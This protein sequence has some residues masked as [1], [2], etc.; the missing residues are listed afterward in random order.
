LLP[1][2]AQTLDVGNEHNPVQGSWEI[3]PKSGNHGREIFAR[4]DLAFAFVTDAKLSTE[5]HQSDMFC[6][7]SHVTIVP[8]QV[9]IVLIREDPCWI[10]GNHCLQL[11]PSLGAVGTAVEQIRQTL[12]G[13]GS[14]GTFAL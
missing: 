6:Q 2:I 1:I 14:F 5:F 8:V 3:I 13:K 4:H 7:S 10:T 11:P 9:V 12:H